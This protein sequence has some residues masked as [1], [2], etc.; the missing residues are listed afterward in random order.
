V[1]G[2]KFGIFS[3]NYKYLNLDILKS[4][5]SSL[6]K[7]GDRLGREIPMLSNVSNG[8]VSHEGDVGRAR[9]GSP[10]TITSRNTIFNC[11]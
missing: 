4:N 10:I 2:Y 1:P 11:Y 5:V 9:S 3:F 6:S 7:Q 8:I